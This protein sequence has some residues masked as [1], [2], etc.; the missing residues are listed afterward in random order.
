MEP[1]EHYL[2]IS[3]EN[4]VYILFFGLELFVFTWHGLSLLPGNVDCIKQ[5][6]AFFFLFSLWDQE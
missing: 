1:G 5:Q 6:T 4:I 3:K 2:D